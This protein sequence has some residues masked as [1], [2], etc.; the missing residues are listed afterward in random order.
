MENLQCMLQLKSN[1][2][3]KIEMKITQRANTK[4]PSSF[5]SQFLITI[6][7]IIDI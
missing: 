3:I 7:K 1:F 2:G 5:R 6:E 4:A